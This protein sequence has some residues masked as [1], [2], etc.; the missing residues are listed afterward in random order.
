MA[1][2]RPFKGIGKTDVTLAGGK[3]ASLGEMTQVSI[4]VPPGFVIL[5]TAFEHFLKETKLHT[6]SFDKMLKEILLDVL[7]HTEEHFDYY[8]EKRNALVE[9]AKKP[10]KELWD[11]TLVRLGGER[12][13]YVYIDDVQKYVDGSEALGVKS[14]RVDITQPDFQERCVIDVSQALGII[15]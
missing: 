2:I 12:S 6:E 9:G 5:S 8:Q 7:E 1:Y 3:G 15:V 14:V 11:A 10:T 4:P 13:G